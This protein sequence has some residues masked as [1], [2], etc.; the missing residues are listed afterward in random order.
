[1]NGAQKALAVLGLLAIVSTTFYAPYEFRAHDQLE[2]LRGGDG[3]SVT[4]V[5][6]APFWKPPAQQY[7]SAFA[8]TWLSKEITGL[9]QLE[10]VRLA[11]ERLFVWW[12]I[13]VAV[14]VVAV[15]LAASRKR[16]PAPTVRKDDD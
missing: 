4:G 6:H 3:L 1:M 11:S 12:G 10:S 8:P 14:T 5:T 15:M 13:V 2:R 9:P 16:P 7:S